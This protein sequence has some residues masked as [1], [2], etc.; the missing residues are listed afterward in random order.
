MRPCLRACV[1][2]ALFYLHNFIENFVFP[3][4]LQTE[5]TKTNVI[6]FRSSILR[7]LKR[8][9]RSSA[10]FFI[11]S[12]LTDLL[13]ISLPVTGVSPSAENKIKVFYEQNVNLPGDDDRVILVIRVTILPSGY[14][15][16]DRSLF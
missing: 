15:C 12:P 7:S 9:T 5:P 6:L 14:T 8:R 13:L 4:V 10:F 1:S 11:K 16:Y 3:N 2:C